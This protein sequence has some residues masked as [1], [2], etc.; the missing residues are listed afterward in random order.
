MRR[1][2]IQQHY[3]RYH[4]A[5]RHNAR[6]AYYGLVTQVD[7]QIGR[8][9][10]AITEGGLWDDT[11]IL[12]TADHGEM[13]WDHD[14]CQKGWFFEGS[15]R[16]PFL[17]IPPGNLRMGLHGSTHAGLTCLAD[18]LPT[19]VAAAG[20][21]P[22]AGIDGRDLLAILRG[23]ARPRTYLEATAHNA[24]KE[25][26][27][28]YAITDGRWKYT[29]F[30]EGGIEQLFDLGSDPRE[31]RNLAGKPAGTSARERLRGEMVGRLARRKCPD[32]VDGVPID[33]P[34][35]PFDER[36]LRTRYWAGYRTEW[37]SHD[38]QH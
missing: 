28:Y 36:D 12:F 37:S 32:V 35:L 14:M 18:I 24:P 6:A 3:D 1:S 13:L 34:V 31:E 15:A 29:W 11:L 17:L 27:W 20:G 33:R 4:D 30:P 25:P 21:E 19:C 16:L 22:P 23:E 26:N 8:L 10:A 7:H 2:R 38:T 5:A 9:L